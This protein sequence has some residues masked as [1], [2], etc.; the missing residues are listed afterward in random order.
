MRL[1][2]E[3]RRLA[4][5][6]SGSEREVREA[7]ASGNTDHIQAEIGDLLF[8]V[9]NVARWAK[10]DPEEALRGMLDRFSR[11]F[12]RMETL[13]EAPLGDLDPETWDVLWNRAKSEVG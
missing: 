6:E 2:A 13:A 4:Q 3:P 8:T 9:V 5:D 12:E 11:R 10:V 1:D 7:L